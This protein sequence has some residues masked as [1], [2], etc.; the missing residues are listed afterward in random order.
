MYICIKTSEEVVKLNK[1]AHDDYEEVTTV[2][3][4]LLTDLS[5]SCS[6]RPLIF[7]KKMRGVDTNGLQ[8]HP[9]LRKSAGAIKPFLSLALHKNEI[10]FSGSFFFSG[11]QSL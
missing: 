6:S 2:T 10:N 9:G 7:W 8:T 4:S 1:H 3:N 11:T 5:I